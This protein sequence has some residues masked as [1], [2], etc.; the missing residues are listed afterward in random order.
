M[1][2]YAVF[3]A[4]L[5]CFQSDIN[6]VAAE[7]PNQTRQVRPVSSTRQTPTVMAIRRASPAVVNIHGQKTVRSTAAGMAGAGGPD[8]FRQVNGMGTGVVIDPAWLRDYQ[9]SRGRRCQ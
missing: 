6:E 2:W 1:G 3:V 9:L 7:A 5:G 4:A 8:S